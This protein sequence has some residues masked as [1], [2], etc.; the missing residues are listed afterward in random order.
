MSYNLSDINLSKLKIKTL[1][2]FLVSIFSSPGVINKLAHR[3]PDADFVIQ[4]SIN[5]CVFAG[6]FHPLIEPRTF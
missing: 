3:M 2:L 6:Q 1:D 4:I 5:F